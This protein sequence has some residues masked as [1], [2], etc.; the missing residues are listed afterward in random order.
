[1]TGDIVLHLSFFYLAVLAALSFFCSNLPPNHTLVSSTSPKAAA[2]SLVGVLMSHEV[3]S[4]V[5]PPAPESLHIG[6][7]NTNTETRGKILPPPKGQPALE[8]EVYKPKGLLGR[9]RKY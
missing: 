9:T 1:M 4:Q 2:S 6:R 8:K 5:V 3:V 7:G